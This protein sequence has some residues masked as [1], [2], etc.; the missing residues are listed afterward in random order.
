MTLQFIHA[1]AIELEGSVSSKRPHLRGDKPGITEKMVSSGGDPQ[2][3]RTG[4]LTVPITATYKPSQIKEAIEHR[5]RGGEI[6][7]PRRSR[8]TTSKISLGDREI[9]PPPLP[10]LHIGRRT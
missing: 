2:P 4:K 10:I 5:Q 1:Y 8:Q 7:I 6:S 3:R 9:L